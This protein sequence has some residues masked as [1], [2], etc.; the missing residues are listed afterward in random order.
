MTK[1]QH[2]PGPW[3]ISPTNWEDCHAGI[4]AGEANSY[5]AVIVGTPNSEADTHLIASAPDL[6]EVLQQAVNKGYMW[7]NDYQLW[8]KASRAIAKAK[9]IE[10]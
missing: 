9:G 2:T 10:Q 6:L 5:I 7:D 8:C 4:Y 3:S 1:A